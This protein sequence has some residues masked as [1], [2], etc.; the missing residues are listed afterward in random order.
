MGRKW[1]LDNPEKQKQNLH[2]HY[3]AN[4]ADWVNRKAIN[5]A[6]VRDL[7]IQA[8]AIPCMDCG[9]RYPPYVMDLDHRDPITK[10]YPPAQ[11]AGNVGIIAAREEIAKCDVVC[12]NCHRAR[13]YSRMQT[14][15]AS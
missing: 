1:V 10:K 15:K 4:K 7:I 5:K 12:S 6:A 14:D 11:M 3:Q 9:V 2:N 8:K 13:T